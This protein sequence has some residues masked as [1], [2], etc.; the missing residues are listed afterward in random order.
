MSDNKNYEDFY[1]KYLHHHQLEHE[2]NQKR[3]RIGLKV[4]IFVPLVFLIISFI[5]DGSKLIFLILWIVSLFG[6]SG[7]LVFIE[8][9]DYKAQER[10]NEYGK[11]QAQPESLIGD[12]AAEAEALVLDKVNTIDDKLEEEQKRIEE[13]IRERL[14]TL[15][16][17]KDKKNQTKEE[18]TKEEE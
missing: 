14:D 1:D 10:L 13:E 17:L 11:I 5:T 16:K 2:K 7:Y 6:I 18:D 8:F 12:I 4:N 15:K 3:I 9:T